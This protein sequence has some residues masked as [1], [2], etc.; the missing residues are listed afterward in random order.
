MQPE[1]APN[2]SLIRRIAAKEVT[3]F[4]AS[5]IA[6]LFLATFAAVTLFVFFWGEAFFSRNI[7]D[8][9]PLFEWMPVL[10]IFL[11]STLTMRLWSEERRT[12]TLEHVLT[13]PVPLWQFVVGKF[14]GC[15][16]LLAIALAMT[17]PLPI[18]VA[19][20]GELDWGPVWAG[21]LATFLLGAAYLSIG[22]FVSARSDNQ[23][24]SLISATAVCGIFYLLGTPT[25]TSFFGNQAGEWLRLLGT[26]S[27]FDAITR[28]VIDLRDL[29]YYLSIIAVF[30]AL[31]T[32]VLER[33]RWAT[34]Q[35]TPHHQKWRTLT[36]L[37]LANALGAN[38]WLGQITALRVDATAGNQY[39]IS[40]ATHGYLQQLQ[41]PLLLRGYFS[42]KTHPLLAPLVP[43]LRDLIQEYEIAGRG[44]VRVEFIDP[45]ANPELEEEANQKFGI[46]PVPFQVADRYQSAIVSSYFNV[47]VQYGDEH[48]VL[49]FQDLIEVKARAEADI[50]VQL[51]NPEHDLTRAIKK[52]LQTYQAGGNLFDTVQGELV[53]NAYV[54][55]AAAL[56]EQLVEFQQ[57]VSR[58]IGEM[59]ENARGRLTTHFIDPDANGGSVGQQIAA[60]Y[61]FRPMAT[62]LFSNESFYFYLTLAQGDQVVQIPLDDLTEGSFER[63]LEAAVKRFATGFT[64]TVALV[65]PAPAPSYPQY[66]MGGGAGP[67]FNQLESFLSADLNVQ[68]EDLSDGQVSGAADI[69]LL[70]SPKD[71]DEKQ[72]FAVDQF[73]MQ[74]GTVIAAT[75]P[76]GA[77]FSSRSLTLQRHNSGLAQWLAHHGLSVDEQV[78]LDPQS[79]AFPVP[80]TRNVGGFQL[81]EMRMLDYPYFVD[82]RSAGLNRDNA[83]TADLP[84][85]TLA[86]ASPISI[87]SEKQGARQVTELFRSSDDAWLSA[88]TDIMPQL[89]GSGLS[90]F[91]PQG[92]RGSHLL[93]VVSAGRFESYFAGKPSPLLASE[94]EADAAGEGDEA[95][96]EGETDGSAQST[97]SGVIDRSPES[98]RI[99]L[100]GSNDFLRDQIIQMTGSAGGSQY[101]NTLQL[102][103]NTVDWSLEDAGLLSIRSRGHFNRTLPPMEQN[104]QM[105][106]EYLNYA[107][108]AL[109][110]GLVALVQH[111]RKKSIER[112][113]LQLLAN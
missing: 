86:W 25:I 93:G 82:I 40:D 34:G 67:R 112:N 29:Y 109:A 68:R 60:D 64:K 57:I 12:G 78:V 20:I 110:L 54:S 104:T 46:Q 13:Q 19:L 101:L 41:E 53:F 1:P 43:Q 45:A 6:Y 47:L 16:L 14:A 22:L 79:A 80:V 52:V 76:Y 102:V 66:G 107:L 56:P 87:D 26:G 85:V 111:R 95:A 10:L 8:V 30:L 99:I 48:Q 84:Q 21:Y 50:D 38:L 33:E 3:L 75:S 106:W 37:L 89:E 42:G 28:G 100:F 77:S 63:N 94:P 74:G 73:L 27:R 36:A 70:A 24:V 97:I 15:L 35:R 65:V 39:S 90:A 23:I 32:F 71:L 51:R 58:I 81:Q 98:A 113:Y 59:E 7:A 44:R 105:F 5:P 92:E 4:F 11:A 2:Y 18:T 69:L 108:A 103:A 88:S 9:R 49:G 61:G 72:L 17:L 55:P 31:N 62:S 83:I 96:P 91:A